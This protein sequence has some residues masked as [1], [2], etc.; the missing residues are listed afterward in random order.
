MSGSPPA[1]NTG[2][3]SVT[4]RQALDAV[5]DEA[6]ERV[7]GR[8]QDGD[9]L[10]RDAVADLPRDPVGGRLELRFDAGMLL[11]VDGAVG[12]VAAGSVGLGEDRG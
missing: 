4:V 8:E 9:L 12:P 5:D 7:E 2:R 6:G 11:E 3:G 1:A 10:E